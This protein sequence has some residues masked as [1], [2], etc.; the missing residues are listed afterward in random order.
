VAVPAGAVAFQLAA[1]GAAVPAELAS[2][3]GLVETLRSQGRK[4]IS[5]LGGD[6]VIGH[7][8]SPCLGG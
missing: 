6:L 3:L 5:L 8:R 7:R 4:N 2:D 1:D